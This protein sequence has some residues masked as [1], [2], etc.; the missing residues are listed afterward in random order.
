MIDYLLAIGLIL[1]FGYLLGKLTH[2]LKITGIVGYIIIG[3]IIGPFCL[4]IVQLS[5]E[6]V[7]LIINFSLGFV[8]FVIG[9]H[10]TL[11]LLKEFGRS[12][13]VILLMESLCAFA[14]VGIGVYFLT[15][16]LTIALIF[17]S[18]APATAPAGTIAVLHTYRAKGILTDAILA[19]VGF[20]DAVAIII[21]VFSIGGIKVLLG[22]TISILTVVI[23]PVIEIGGAVIV[24]AGIGTLLALVSNKIKEREEMFVASI[25][26]ILVCAGLAELFQLSLILACMVLGMF[27]INIIP[28]IGRTARDVVENIMLPIYIIFFVVAGISLRVDLLIPMGL[29]G[30]IYI[31]CRSVGKIGGASFAAKATRANP[32]LR[33]YLGFALLS[34]AGVAIGLASLVAVELHDYGV[35]GAHLGALAITVI[36]ATTVVFEII[37]PIGVRFAITKAG[38]AAKS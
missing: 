28:A 24:G 14:L 36:A 17:A 1:T 16:D 11:S 8:A 13:V 22:G 20:D 21:F 2:T 30:V 15:K 12:I 35:E 7:H 34:Q 4:N 5:S 32:K 31:I 25:A 27:L 10:L 9:A 38:E 37:G 33:R 26:C 29:L 23:T 6:A 3:I 19:I 18:L